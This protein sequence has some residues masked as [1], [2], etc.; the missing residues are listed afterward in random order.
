MKE[1][2]VWLKTT[3]GMAVETYLLTTRAADRKAKRLTSWVNLN[4]VFVP[5][6][7]RIDQAK[8][9]TPAFFTCKT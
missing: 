1:I 4:A 6:P 9:R 5:V 2:T 7:L 8:T 3:A